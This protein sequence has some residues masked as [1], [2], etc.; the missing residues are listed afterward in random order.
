M[1]SNDEARI[2]GGQP[3]AG[4]GE[5]E[6]FVLDYLRRETLDPAEHDLGPEDNLLTSGAVDSVSIMRLIGSLE[7]RLGVTVPPAEMVPVNFRTVRTMAAYLH[8]LRG[9]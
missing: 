2:A 6:T 5:I 7:E 3:L 4:P 8:G 9:A 1:A